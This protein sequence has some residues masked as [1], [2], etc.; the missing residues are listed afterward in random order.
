MQE[1]IA[2][3]KEVDGMKKKNVKIAL[4]GLC[5]LMLTALFLSSCAPARQNGTEPT[6]EE[7]AK[8]ESGTPEPTRTPTP[9]VTPTPTVT[10]MPTETPTPTVTPDPEHCSHQPSAGGTYCVKCHAALKKNEKEYKGMIYFACDDKTL[11]DAYKI[12]VADATGN[13][14]DY[15]AGAL[16][17]S[18]KCIIAGAGYSTPWTRDTAINVWN[19]FALLDPEVSKNTLLSVV[20]K[21]GKGYIIDGQYWDAVIWGIGAYAYILTTGDEGFVPVAQ[22]A[23]ANSL[24]KYEA[25]EFDPEDG[26][27]RGPAV[28]GDGIS[29]YPDKY[30]VSTHSGIE[31]WPGAAENK[32]LRAKKGVGIPMKALSTNCVYYEAYNVLAALNGMMGEDPAPALEKAEKLKDAINRIFWNEKKGTYDYL[33]YECDHQEALGIAFALL[34]GV[35]DARRTA[36]VLENAKICEHGIA[37]VYPTFERFSALGGYGRHSGTIW[38]HAQGFWARAA[39]AGGYFYEFENELRLLAE[40]AVRDGQFYEIYHPDTGEVYGGLQSGGHGDISLWGSCE[41][42][43]W[44]ATAYL[45]LIY[46]H[47]LGATVEK[48][49]VSFK[50]YLPAG[51]NE[52]SV[53]GFKVGKTTF[54]VVIVRNGEGEK[55][56]SFDTTEEKTV[57]LFLSVN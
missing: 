25:Q 33:A 41:H 17:S 31:G 47:L 28:Y 23:L 32:E 15:K 44:S 45:S 8:S 42:Q 18:A 43:T 49:K 22:S 37:C 26:L 51:V 4:R 30:A 52:A 7:T 39:F 12:A 27:F 57:R 55:E 3:I 14:K 50:P 48:G 20:K 54:D 5:L 46:Y 21:Q 40:K 24:K 13:V 1:Q 6:K 56:A 11:T 29:A 35:A 16:E 34:F 10:P 36:L 38:P 2:L 53:S 9:S 19:A